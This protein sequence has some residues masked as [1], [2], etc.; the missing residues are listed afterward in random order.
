MPMICRVRKMM[1]P[2][3]EPY[4]AFLKQLEL[5]GD[6]GENGVEIQIPIS[7][8]G[9]KS[10]FR[11]GFWLDGHFYKDMLLIITICRLEGDKVFLR[12]ECNFGYHQDTFFH[13]LEKM[14][15]IEKRMDYFYI[16]CVE[17]LEAESRLDHRGHLV[18]HATT[19]ER[20]VKEVCMSLMNLHIA[21]LAQED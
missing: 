14:E 4:A 18:F 6:Y 3:K 9:S 10:K 21:V 8:G 13:H 20:F 7:T 2:E 12:S 1:S 15:Q 17:E 19:R 11:A 5:A 16:P